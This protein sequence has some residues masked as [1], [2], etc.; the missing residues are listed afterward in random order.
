VVHPG[1][2]NRGV[3]VIHKGGFNRGFGSGVFL[4][5]GLGAPFGY[6]YGGYG[7]YGVPYDSG[8]NAPDY[9]YAPDYS[10]AAP[11]YAAP[12]GSPTPSVYNVPDGS[13][14]GAAA[15]QDPIAHIMVKVP[16]DAEVWFGQS[17]TSQTGAQRE[18][19]SPA[20]TAGQN[21]T[22]DIKARWTEGGKEVVQ[23]RQI[24]ISSGTW[25]TVDFT[26]AAPEQLDAPK[27]KQ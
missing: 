24:E 14:G 11:Y 20:L 22:Y 3:T 4:G 16:T 7:G 25:K 23:T 10:A 8:Y 5:V 21:Y 13:A 1:G 6:G 9:G 2:F 19:V 27:P 12:Q 18:F 17:K 26:R 15:T